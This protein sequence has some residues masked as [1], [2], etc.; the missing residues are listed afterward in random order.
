VNS[1]Y[2]QLGVADLLSPIDA[3]YDDDETVDPTFDLDASVR[4][5]SAHQLESFNENWMLQLDR[6][7]RMSLS[8][9]LVRYLKVQMGK[10]ERQRQPN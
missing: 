6:D 8:I 3:P 1:T 5:D 9:F 7:N 2:V 10:G 4:S